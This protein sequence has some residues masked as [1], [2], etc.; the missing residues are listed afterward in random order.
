MYKYNR[1][2]SD[3]E[4]KSKQVCRNIRCNIGTLCI[5]D[6]YV[7]K[8]SIYNYCRSYRNVGYPVNLSRIRYVHVPLLQA[9]QGRCI[10]IRG[11]YLEQESKQVH[12]NIIHTANR[13]FSEA[14]I[15]NRKVNRYI[16]ILQVMQGRWMS[17][18]PIW[19]T[20]VNTYLGPWTSGA[21]I[22]YKKVYIYRDYMISYSY[23]KKCLIY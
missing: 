9:V 23:G 2:Y 21:R 5:R 17:G 4:Q 13:R 16:Q 15:W 10:N 11:T 3:V 14:P 12:T 1:Q 7:E 22:W 19:N 20:K 8:E 6:T 18:T